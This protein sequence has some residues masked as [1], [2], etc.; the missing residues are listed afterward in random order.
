MNLLNIKRNDLLH[1]KGTLQSQID[2]IDKML[3]IGVAENAGVSTP[4]ARKGN[5]QGRLSDK[6]IARRAKRLLKSK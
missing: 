3:Q 5:P 2:L 6:A 1:M 4:A